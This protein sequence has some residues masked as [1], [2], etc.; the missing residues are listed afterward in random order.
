ALVPT[1]APSASAQVAPLSQFSGYSTGTAVHADAL[2]N[3]TSRLE[4]TEVAFSAANVNSGGLGAALVNEMDQ[5]YQQATTVADKAAGRGSGVEVGLATVTPNVN[6]ANQ[7]NP[8]STV[9][10]FAPESTGLLTANFTTLNLD[11]VINSEYLRGQ[12]QAVYSDSVCVL[13]QP[14]SSGLGYAGSAALV[15]TPSAE[16]LASNTGDNAVS[17]SKS[18]TYL[19]PNIVNGVAD[20]T[21]GLVTETHQI[22]APITIFPGTTALPVAIPALPVVGVITVEFGGEWVLRSTAT[23][24]AGGAK[25]EYAPVGAATPTT[26]VITVKVDGTELAAITLQD[27]L[28]NDG[29]IVPLPLDLG[30]ISIGA[31]PRAIGGNPTSTP[32]LLANG[33]KAAAAVDVVQIT[34]QLADLGL[35]DLRVG[36]MES[37]AMVPIGGIQCGIP[38]KKV[39]TPASVVAGQDQV[40]NYTITIPADVE[41]FKAIA[42]D[43]VNIKVVDVTTA[44]PGV[45][46]DIV[47][48]SSGGVISGGDTVTW[49][50]LGKYT[51]GDAPIVLTVGLKVPKDSAAGKITD[52]ATA[53]AVLGNCKGNASANATSLTGLAKAEAAAL[54]GSDAFSGT[55]TT[56]ATAAVVA[57]AAG[58]ATPVGGVQTGAGGTSP[59]SSP[60]LPI[61]TALGSVALVA[62]L[63]AWRRRR[64]S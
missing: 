35:A 13:G 45:K 18:F 46:F 63:T 41:A 39:G 2:Q 52:T 32:E 22:L 17:Q 56:V 51:P 33:T 28:D 59:I 44:E 19:I 37:M 12:A 55:T 8:G 62:S 64:E 15:G 36:H 20:G 3:G 7:I 5:A 34:G 24:K 38:V 4:D 40:V 11:P 57:P 47:S 58:G 42:C 10:A 23:G 50:N 29:L 43:I 26:K 9:Q 14:I 6:G 21:Y 25:V 30:V 31:P 48:A 16:L 53:T 27:I 60:M 61:G 49:A 54:T 1:A